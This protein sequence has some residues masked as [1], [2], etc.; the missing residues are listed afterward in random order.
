[1]QFK[2]GRRPVP[3]AEFQPQRRLMLSTF[4][5]GTAHLPTPPLVQHWS[6]A[7]APSLRQIY[8][9]DQ[10]SCCTASGAGHAIGTWRAN[11][12]NGDGMPTDADVV[13]FYSATTG[14]RAGHPET[15][16]G[17]NE[18]EVLTHWRDHGFFADGTGRI[19]GWVDVDG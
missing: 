15:D 12:G 17:G 7:A 2:L 6:Q 14:Y 10:L 16:Q 4:L 5:E 18:V 1:M 19:L 8:A 9:N 3:R 13:N 11:A